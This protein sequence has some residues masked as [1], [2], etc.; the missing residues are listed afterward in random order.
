MINSKEI[1]DRVNF[2]VEKHQPLVA[3]DPYRLY[4][5]LMPSVGLL[6]DPNGFVYY[7]GE[8][9]I[10][11]QWNPF[12]T[13]H[14]SKFWG[15]SVSTD[16]VHWKEAPIIL[17]PGEWYDKN[18]C[19]SGSAVVFED[20]MYVFYT[21]NVKDEN[22]KRDSY[23]CLAVSKD[24][25][26]FEK[27]GPVINVPDG[28]T[29]HFRDPK[30]FR[31]NNKW[32][33]VLGAQTDAGTGEAVYYTSNN[34]YDWNFHGTLAGS[35][36]NGLGAFGYMWECPDFFELGGTDILMVCPQGIEAKGYE[37]QNVFQ[38][39]YFSGKINDREEIF[40][41]GPFR[42]MDRGFDFYAPQTTSGPNGRRLVFGWM[43]NA[44]DENSQQP[45]TKYEWVH[46]LTLPR[47]L[48]WKN[49]KLL[50]HPVEE[51]KSLRGKEIKFEN[52]RLEKHK[53]LRFQ[54]LVFEMIVDFNSFDTDCLT[55][56]IG[57]SKLIYYRKEQLFTFQR[58]HFSKPGL[59]EVR[60]CKLKEL[61][62]IH[63]FKDTSS[64]E[65]FLNNGEEVFTSRV[66]DDN[67]VILLHIEDG[68]ATLNIQ[69][70]DLK[71]VT[72]Y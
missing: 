54:E 2:L 13:A 16:L 71:R 28:Y 59:M 47:E 21:G 51:L 46:A 20:Q 49:G 60:H 12:A 56:E 6:N 32:Y 67:N 29:A 8:Y 22:G 3:S 33:M 41:H 30:V 19:Y 36:K 61:R 23:Q 37:Y 68:S 11:Y 38:T 40:Q 31:K 15:H 1:L 50:Q 9:H 58:K 63:I 48:K 42:E 26:H 57:E 62:S 45:T 44:E 66:F 17:A 10:F 18:G 53:A 39:G 65:L 34:L 5:H 43:G 52:T 35:G 64:I 27:K 70:W 55:I 24:G 72:T 14:G 25:I 7:R 69:K 4:Y